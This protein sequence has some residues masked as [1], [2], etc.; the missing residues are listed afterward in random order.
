MSLTP[1]V[2]QTPL[3]RDQEGRRF[4]SFSP[5]PII[6]HSGSD[7]ESLRLELR[8]DTTRLIEEI[9]QQ[10]RQRMHES[11]SDNWKVAQV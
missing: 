4:E 3:V 2:P 8:P 7:W 10:L 11:A 9:K 5:P 6:S 1:P